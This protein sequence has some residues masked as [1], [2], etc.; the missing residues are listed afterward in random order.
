MVALEAMSYGLPC[1]FSDLPVH[2]EITAN[3]RAALLFHRGDSRDLRAA[4]ISLIEDDQQRHQFVLRRGGWFSS[5]YFLNRTAGISICFCRTLCAD[6]ATD[7]PFQ[8]DK[9]NWG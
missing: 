4:L 3:G 7:A 1:V 2:S 6:E 8:P 5:V 9:M